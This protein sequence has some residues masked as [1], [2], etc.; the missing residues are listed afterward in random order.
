MDKKSD[1]FVA[2][3]AGDAA[4]AAELTKKYLGQ[5]VDPQAILTE[6]MIPALG[7]V[8]DRFESGELFIPELLISARAMKAG[9]ALIRPLLAQSPSASQQGR[10]VI[11]TVQGDLHDIGKNIVS[12]MLEGGGFEVI[13]LGIGVS[14]EKFTEAIRDNQASILAMSALL[15]TTMSSMRATIEA[16]RNAGLREHVKVMVGGAPVTQTFAD[17]IGADGF[18]NNA[19]GALALARGWIQA[20]ANASSAA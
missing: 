1:L 13:D 8:G 18:S 14:P 9:L 16:L 19:N 4:K 3:I 10:V 5:G 12:A 11:G 15:T 6:H 17:E 7:N 20:K 2:I